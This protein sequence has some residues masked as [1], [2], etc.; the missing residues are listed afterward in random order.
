LLV[1]ACSPAPKRGARV[2]PAQ[3]EVTSL[4]P[5]YSTERPRG[6]CRAETP[7]ASLDVE[8]VNRGAALVFTTSEDVRELRERVI[9]LPSSPTIRVDR[10]RSDNIPRGVRLIFEAQ[11]GENVEALRRALRVRAKELAEQCVFTFGRQVEP[12][13]EISTPP[14]TAKPSTPAPIEPPIKTETEGTKPE[15]AKPDVA[16]GGRSKPDL[17]SDAEPAKPP[18]SETPADGGKPSDDD[19][20]RYPFP[21]GDY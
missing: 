14:P 8:D 1:A 6:T 15:P 10:G 16:D 9:A 4:E 7:E 20:P 11:P 12:V 13:S 18:E 5:A 2:Q 19:K 3:I 21:R 17:A